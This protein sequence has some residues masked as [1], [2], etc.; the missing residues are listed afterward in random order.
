MIFNGVDLSPYFKIKSITGRGFTNNQLLITEIS[1]ADGAYVHGSKRQPRTL[2]INGDIIAHDEESLRLTVDYLNGVLN[3]ARD[4]PI[5]FSDEPDITYYGRPSASEEGEEKFFKADGTLTIF[6]GD[7][8]KYGKEHEQQINN[9]DGN[10]DGSN[11]LLLK[12]GMNEVYLDYEGADP[13]GIGVRTDDGFDYSLSL[14][15]NVI[16][17]DEDIE[18]RPFM[19]ADHL[20][21]L[22]PTFDYTNVWTYT[23]NSETTI[24]S[25]TRIEM[26]NVNEGDNGA[27][28]MNIELEKGKT[29]TLYCDHN[30]LLMG[31]FIDV[32]GSEIQDLG[33]PFNYIENKLV[34]FTVP[35]DDRIV[36]LRLFLH[37]NRGAL[38]TTF[39]YQN[40]MLFEGEIS[41]SKLPK[42]YIYGIQGIKNPTFY[43]TH[44]SKR[45]L[46][47]GSKEII[48]KT[49][50]ISFSENIKIRE[51][52]IITISFWAKT[53]SRSSDRL[54]TQ[55][56][57]YYGD[58][59][60]LDRTSTHPFDA[61]PSNTWRF[62]SNTFEV[63][64]G[65]KSMQFYA[66]TDHDDILIRDVKIEKSNSPTDRSVAP[67]L[68]TNRIIKFNDEF[69]REDYLTIS[70]LNI[71]KSRRRVMRDV[72]NNF[73]TL[74]SI[75][76]DVNSDVSKIIRI[77]QFMD[78]NI[79][80]S[81]TFESTKYDGT[82]LKQT[83]NSALMVEGD[84]IH[85]GSSFY[86]VSVWNKD[87]GWGADYT[88]TDEEIKAYLLG[89][90]MYG[91]NWSVPYNGTGTKVWRKILKDGKYG[92]NPITNVNEA[93]T[94]P[95][96]EIG[97]YRVLAREKIRHVFPYGVP[98]LVYK[99][100]QQA[101]THTIDM[102]VQETTDR[103]SL[104]NGD[105]E[106]RLIYQFSAG[107]KVFLDFKRRKI[108]I[109]D[110]ISMNVI[111]MLA[112]KFWD[113]NIG[114]NN[115]RIEPLKIDAVLKYREVYR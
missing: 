6:C 53:N 71:T 23:N 7:P 86:F 51:G 109:N 83:A 52:D 100:T 104:F 62:F 68:D 111:S 17:V 29:Y 14:G 102:T 1:G 20:V 65:T 12:K 46:Y 32:N 38:G 98:I 27:M 107:D 22:L 89:W 69:F 110:E 87:S 80:D 78:L 85:T 30:R 9:K 115:I 105:K 81:G 114:V 103:I 67:E 36:G 43:I 47:I 99:G 95:N 18:V 88:P 37:T 15:S 66:R 56:V 33:R 49:S 57:G 96:E 55:L 101:N 84:M 70:S 3:V 31:L 72:E 73:N 13:S 64:S 34:V 50:W 77:H 42:N 54:P 26:K 91:E 75:H 76:E 74:A 58:N 112:P 60:T 63:A 90:R 82:V 79:Y 97:R 24:L 5:I 113:L 61:Y 93:L 59:G 39:Y 108:L 19:V 44:G 11:K 41:D 8:N 48:A 45:N 94:D 10:I 16:N 25:P 4:V 92:A 28:Y 21:N 106:L 40:A 35:D 2:S